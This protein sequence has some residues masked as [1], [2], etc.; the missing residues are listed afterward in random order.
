ME[1][2][3]SM[4]EVI[5][6]MEVP[7]WPGVY[8]LGCFAQYITLYSQQVRAL[9][10]MFALK[11]AGH[12]KCDTRVAV[13]GGGAAG[14]TAAVAAARLGAKVTL[15]EKLGD[16][17]S[18]QLKSTKRYIHP[19]NYNWPAI[20]PAGD[21][22]KLPVLDWKAD[23]ADEVAT[24]LGREWEKERALYKT[25]LRPVL[26]A[27]YVQIVRGTENGQKVIEVTW[28]TD[29]GADGWPFDII[30]LAI[31]FGLEPRGGSHSPYWDDDSLDKVDDRIK[32]CLVSG[33]GDGGLTD[34]MRLC[35]RNFRHDAIITMFSADAECQKIGRE[36][37]V[38]EERYRES[39][40]RWALTEFYQ[41]L[42]V[43]SV[44]KLLRERRRIDTNVF[45]T[46]R[47]GIQDVYTSRSS[48]LNRFIVSQLN[49]IGAWTWMNGPITPNNGF[50][51]RG[52]YVIRFGAGPWGDREKREYDVLVRRYGPESALKAGFHEIYSA[53]ER[54]GLITRWKK[55]AHHNDP[56]RQSLS[57]GDQFAAPTLVKRTRRTPPQ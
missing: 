5:D 38:Q 51:K 39:H 11:E 29:N 41:S 31:G 47:G 12:L 19:H 8:V 10:L 40:D 50:N 24:H 6:L 49:R 56:T 9:N 36:L 16:P 15:L 7:E 46:G 55:M 32:E 23:Y 17:M 37:L 45:L 2:S 25:R 18:M 43:E 30:V 42:N 27:Q 14:L 4:G 13:V 20:I 57:W 3:S 26:G 28:K 1:S 52:R 22:A 48:I 33:C 35:I 54:G 44:K 53:C 21:F 34:L